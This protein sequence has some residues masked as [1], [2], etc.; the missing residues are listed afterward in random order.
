MPGLKQILNTMA[1]D[2]KSQ[3]ELRAHCIQT[4]G[5]ILTAVKDRPDICRADALEVAATLTRLL[6]SGT[7]AESD[8]QVLAIQNTLSQIGACIKQEFKQ[9]LPLIMPALLKDIGR[10]I[11][12]KIVDA[13]LAGSNDGVNTQLKVK[14]AGVEGER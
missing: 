5:F 11:D 9:F 4:I 8:P 3:Q 1:M 2:T 12:L 10:D 14:I 6:N 7:V 13:D